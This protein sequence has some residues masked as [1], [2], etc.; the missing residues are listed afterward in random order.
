[1][2]QR[3]FGLAPKASATP[4]TIPVNAA[5]T[6]RVGHEGMAAPGGMGTLE[7]AAPIGTRYPQN[8]TPM[9]APVSVAASEPARDLRAAKGR[10]MRGPETVELGCGWSEDE[11]EG[12][13][14]GDEKK[15]ENG[16]GRDCGRAGVLGPQRRPIKEAVVSHQ[17]SLQD[18]CVGENSK[19]PDMD[20]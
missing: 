9:A 1:M 17:E 11:E 8:P 5:T 10:G 16:R 19:H 2:H 7:D 12:R 6:P 18:A 15:E 4:A 14:E 20:I 3:G 13:G